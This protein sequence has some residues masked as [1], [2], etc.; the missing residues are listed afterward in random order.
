MILCAAANG[1][2]EDEGEGGFKGKEFKEMYG[3]EGGGVMRGNSCGVGVAVSDGAVKGKGKG[4]K[5][6]VGLPGEF[7]IRSE[8]FSI[9]C[10]ASFSPTSFIH[11][12]LLPPTHPL[13]HPTQRN[14][15]PAFP[16]PR[17]AIPAF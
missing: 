1:D 12:T 16:L 3:V 6:T 8:G 9:R 2:N 17:L 15:P 10:R 14:Q 4:V 7:M 13:T 5:G 11:L